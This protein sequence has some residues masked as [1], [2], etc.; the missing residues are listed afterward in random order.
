[1]AC[2]STKADPSRCR[3]GD[4]GRATILTM[5][6]DIDEVDIALLDALHVNP[7]A[8]FDEVGRALD[9]SAVTV[10][11][12]WHGLVANGQAWVSSMPG[13]RLPVKAA[14]FE[15]ECEPGAAS[16]VTTQFASRPHLFSVNVTSGRDNVYALLVAADQR[17]L[18]EL[19][20]DVLPATP[21]LC[22]VRSALITQLFS[23]ASWR[24]GGLSADQLRAVKPAPAMAT[25]ARA[26]DDFDRELY[27]ALQHDGRRSLRELAA[28]VG[29][30]ESTVRRRIALLTRTGLLGYRTDFARVDAGW[31]TSVA[32]TLR[33]AEPGVAAVGRALVRYPEVRFCV[34]TTG[35]GAANLFVTMQLHDLSDLDAVVRRLVG[36]HPSVAVLETRVVLRAVKSWGRILGPDGRAH[37]VVPV[38]LWAPVS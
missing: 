26:F 7:L 22:R 8:S 3:D 20:V 16:S 33:V 14:V 24:L 36:G 23:G 9:V 17:L 5:G 25:Q 30:S 4:D 6:D 38:D 10:A 34:A 29:R 31:P 11:R 13:P 1:M 32:L 35:G 2:T 28:A 19:I 15:A 18:S 12:R 21:G 27:L 37:A